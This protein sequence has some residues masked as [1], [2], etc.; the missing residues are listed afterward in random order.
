[1]PHDGVQVCV[2]TDASGY[3]RGDVERRRGGAGVDVTSLCHYGV[4]CVDG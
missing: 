2:M 4:L 3:Y 1:M